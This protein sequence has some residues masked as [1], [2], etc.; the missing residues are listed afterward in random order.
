MVREF[1]QKRRVELCSR[2]VDLYARG[3]DSLG[4]GN[5]SIV[6]DPHLG[7]LLPRARYTGSTS[8]GWEASVYA[9]LVV[10]LY[11]WDPPAPGAAGRRE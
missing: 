1:P 8:W 6:K 10:M 4:T 2:G 11:M 9:E 7:E 3:G 5:G